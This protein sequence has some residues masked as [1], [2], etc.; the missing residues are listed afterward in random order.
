M[1]TLS[2]L[3]QSVPWWVRVGVKIVLARLPVPYSMW[4]RLRLFEHGDMN[5][6]Q[7][8][9]D[10]FIEHAGS[11]GV[12]EDGLTLPRLASMGRDFNV[13]ELGPGDSLFTAVIAK[14]LG[15]SRS[16]LVDA[17]PFA[18]KDMGAFVGLFDF[19]HQ[20]G[21]S[22]AFANG[23]QTP[24]D[25]LTQCHGEY[26]TEGVQSLAQLPNAC[27]DF[28][29]SNAVLEHIPKEDFGK[30]ADEL[31]RILKPDGVCLHRVDL[32]DHLGGG[33]NNL[34][35]S[36]ARWEGSLFRKSGFYT[37]R[38]RFGQMVNVFVQAGFECSLPRVL[39]W[40]SL[41]ISRTKLDASF[42]QLIEDD[43]LVSGFDIVLKVKKEVA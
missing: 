9:Y 34:R 37:N 35:F 12:L 20:T 42:R 33:L 6:P 25:V 39:R 28:C 24:A 40:G 4:K 27:I 13:L 36:D 41:P 29:F 2:R 7:R 22:L 31:R 19:L 30:L 26:L 8:A 11:A 5:Q 1:M 23:P 38:I 17:G 10:T 14:A 32:K 3:R 15:A 43:L 21:F 18:T 16:W